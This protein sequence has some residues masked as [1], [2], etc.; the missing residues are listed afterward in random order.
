MPAPQD[1]VFARIKDWIEDCRREHGGD[2]QLCPACQYH[3]FQ[4][5]RL[6]RSRRRRLAGLL[7][8]QLLVMFGMRQ[9]QRIKSPHRQLIDQPRLCLKVIQDAITIASALGYR[10]L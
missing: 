10:Y 5:Y 2:L 3:R 4:T 8:M 6:R 1:V 7:D 9:G